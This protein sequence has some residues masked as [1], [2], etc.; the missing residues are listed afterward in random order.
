MESGYFDKSMK[1]VEESASLAQEDPMEIMADCDVDFDFDA[2]LRDPVEDSQSVL[3]R[4]QTDVEERQNE[5]FE[6]G[7]INQ[8]V[9]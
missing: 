3:L 6:S 8:D 5:Y 9:I 7:Y 2:N 4:R 1:Q